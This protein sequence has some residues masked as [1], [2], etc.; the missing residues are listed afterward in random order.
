M[1]QANGW[2]PAQLTK[3]KWKGSFLQ[4][5]SCVQGVF[6]SKSDKKQTEY[7]RNK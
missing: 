5:G 1:S 3:L 6:C 2:N 7:A 4:R